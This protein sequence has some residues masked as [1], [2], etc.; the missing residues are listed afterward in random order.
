[1]INALIAALVIQAGLLAFSHLAR[2]LLMHRIRVAMRKSSLA[3]GL[4]RDLLIVMQVSQSRYGR[5]ELLLWRVAHWWLVFYRLL[6]GMPPMRRIPTPHRRGASE[7]TG[8]YE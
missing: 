4:A 1:V 7:E 6:T 2:S 5:M 8:E 3:P